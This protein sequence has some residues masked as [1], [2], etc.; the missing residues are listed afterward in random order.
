MGCYFVRSGAPTR[1]APNSQIILTKN[2]VPHAFAD[3]PLLLWFPADFRSTS[4]QIQV[5][6][7]LGA[8]VE[9]LGASA[10]VPEGLEAFLDLGG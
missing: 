3:T 9:G 8:S 5:L 1:P 2:G 10:E 4:L 7:G 6:G